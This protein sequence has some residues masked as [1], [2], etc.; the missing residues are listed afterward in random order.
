MKSSNSDWNIKE[1]NKVLEG[2]TAVAQMAKEDAIVNKY[3]LEAIVTFMREK[4]AD[5]GKTYKEEKSLSI[6]RVLLCSIYP[7]RVCWMYPGISNTEISLYYQY[8]RDINKAS[9]AFGDPDEIRTRDFRDEN[10][11]S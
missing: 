8:I 9:A 1:Q 10:P 3:N 6:K 7:S 11:T 5:L 4:F 2:K